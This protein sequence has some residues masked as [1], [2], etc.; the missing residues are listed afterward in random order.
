MAVEKFLSTTYP[1]LLRSDYLVRVSASSLSCKHDSK[2]NFVYDC[3]VE[4]SSNIVGRCENRLHYTSL[5]LFSLFPMLTC[6]PAERR[7]IIKDLCWNWS[8]EYEFYP[9]GEADF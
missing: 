3:L 7:R 9:W 6:V 1:H 8:T 2:P 5:S 4:L